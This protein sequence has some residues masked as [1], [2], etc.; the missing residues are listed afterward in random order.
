M[1]IIK[2]AL[3]GLAAASLSS[4]LLVVVA[5]TIA[6]RM[7]PRGSGVL[8]SGPVALLVAAIAFVS[9]YLWESNRLHR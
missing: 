8:I 6:R 5:L 1:V 4:A 3:V 7:A 9:G 2:S